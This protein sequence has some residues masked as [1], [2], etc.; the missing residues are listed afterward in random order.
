MNTCLT[1]RSGSPFGKSHST[2]QKQ[3]QFSS[4][5]ESHPLKSL[6]KTKGSPG[7]IT[8]NIYLGVYLDKTLTFR[9]HIRAAVA[10]WLRYPTMAGMS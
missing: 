7:L 4:R 6:F 5:K 8:P 9:Q 2:A 10:Q 1:L 3:R